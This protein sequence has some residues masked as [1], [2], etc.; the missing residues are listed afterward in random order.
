MGFLIQPPQT[1]TIGD[2]TQKRLG[3]VTKTP[4][5]LIANTAA[6]ILAAD[7]TASYGRRVN[8]INNASSTATVYIAMGRAATLTDYDF[9]LYPLNQ[10]IDIDWNMEI[11]SA[12]STGTPAIIVNSSKYEEI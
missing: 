2:V 11:I 3:A 8:S 5:T 1:T 7:A 12:I 6:N 10:L 4:T 9:I